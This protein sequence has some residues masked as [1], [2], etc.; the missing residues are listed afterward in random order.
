MSTEPPGARKF[1]HHA[2]KLRALGDVAQAREFAA[3]AYQ[4]ANEDSD[5]EMVYRSRA[6]VGHMYLYRA[7]YAESYEWYR[8][9]LKEAESGRVT[10]WIGPA[11]HDCWVSGV[12][13]GLTPDETNPYG[14]GLAEGWGC[15]PPQAWRFLHDYY[16]IRDTDNRGDPRALASAAIS[17]SWYTIN[18][19][20]GVDEYQ[21]YA[22]MFERMIVFASM[23]RGFGAR[24]MAESWRRAMNCF[25]MA[26]DELGTEEGYALCLLEAAEGARLVGEA[27]IAVSLIERAGV[28]A[29]RRREVEVVR[30]AKEA[31]SGVDNLGEESEK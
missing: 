24:G 8:A 7:E 18:R 21:R 14:A 15:R 9:A 5:A 23:A 27:A 20:P 30:L 17:A 16:L 29:A 25:D 12:L 28:V 13:A 22:A 2:R 3:A 26:A 1:L 6:A 10:D 4:M 31:R 11:H 19:A